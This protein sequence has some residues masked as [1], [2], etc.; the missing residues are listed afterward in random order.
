MREKLDS[1]VKD[2]SVL[3]YKLSSAR[4]WINEEI[5]ER[6]KVTRER[7]TLCQQLNAVRKILLK[8]HYA[9]LPENAKKE[10][11]FL[12]STT[13]TS[14]YVDAESGD[15]SERFNFSPV[16]NKDLDA[17]TFSPKC[18]PTE[19]KSDLDIDV[20]SLSA[21]NTPAKYSSFVKDLNGVT[22][23]ELLVTPSTVRTPIATKSLRVCDEFV[24]SANKRSVPEIFSPCPTNSRSRNLISP[25]VLMKSSTATT[26]TCIDANKRHNFINR[27]FM[28]PES[29]TRCYRKIAFGGTVL[30]CTGCAIVIHPECR[31]DVLSAC[32]SY[33]N[34]SRIRKMGLLTDY[35]KHTLPPFVPGVVVDIVREIERRGLQDEKLYR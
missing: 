23:A 29:C 5:Q 10:L 12:E 1:A 14:D 30:K 18:T 26:P 6:M 19:E 11:I 17:G 8:D 20:L 31:D 33:L 16:L 32:K 28:M 21:R 13:R 4:R 15:R 25:A 35:L 22:G 34:F 2:I 24:G 9:V 7:D 27:T 3:E